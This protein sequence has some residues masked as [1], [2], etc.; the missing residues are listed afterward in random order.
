MKLSG[1]QDIDPCES[2][3]EGLV[4]EVGGQAVW[5]LSSCKLGKTFHL[6]D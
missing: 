2:E 5:S 6:V 1:G 3:R 4:R